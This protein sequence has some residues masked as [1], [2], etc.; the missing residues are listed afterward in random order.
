MIFDND[1]SWEHVG[2]FFNDL[3]FWKIPHEAPNCFKYIA[4][5]EEKWCASC[6]ISHD[7]TN[8]VFDC[9]ESEEYFEHFPVLS[10]INFV[11]AVCGMDIFINTESYRR[12]KKDIL[13]WIMLTDQFKWFDIKLMG[14]GERHE[15]AGILY[16]KP[17]KFEYLKLC[18]N[19]KVNS[20]D[21][22]KAP[23]NSLGI[24]IP[25]QWY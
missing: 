23:P 3:D 2:S 4:T 5:L 21:V 8:G 18:G 20:D 1:G 6:I 9:S 13:H 10:I 14:Y 12:N 15:G 17:E 7:E 19:K 24:F 16:L 25:F 22:K 11:T